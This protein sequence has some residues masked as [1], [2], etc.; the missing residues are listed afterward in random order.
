MLE[1]TRGSLLSLGHPIWD[2]HEASWC[3]WQAPGLGVRKPVLTSWSYVALTTSLISLSCEFF[4]CKM[5]IIKPPRA[6]VRSKCDYGFIGTRQTSGCHRCAINCGSRRCLLFWDAWFLV[7]GSSR[8]RI[9]LSGGAHAGRICASLVPPL[10]PKDIRR[11]SRFPLWNM[12]S[13][14]ST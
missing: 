5:E 9:F 1:V 12:T 4:I 6:T 7:S 3:R 10:P 14:P 8:V 11:V 2:R 13:L